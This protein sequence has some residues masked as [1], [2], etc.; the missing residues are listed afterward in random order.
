[1]TTDRNDDP[2]DSIIAGIERMLAESRAIDTKKALAGITARRL[3]PKARK[4]SVFHKS[5][6]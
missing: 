2:T 3:P 4:H 1:M 6:R 5:Y